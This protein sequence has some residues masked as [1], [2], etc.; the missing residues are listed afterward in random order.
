MTRAQP[1]KKAGV[2][3]SDSVGHCFRYD[4]LLWA[5]A[6]C[7]CITHVRRTQMWLEPTQVRF[8]HHLFYKD[9]V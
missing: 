4:R 8:T 5:W 3:L 9:S 1:L 7:S 2:S 6:L